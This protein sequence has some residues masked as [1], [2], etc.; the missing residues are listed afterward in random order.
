MIFWSDRCLHFLLK[1]KNRIDQR[2]DAAETHS[3][4]IDIDNNSNENR[5][6]PCRDHDDTM[7]NAMNNKYLLKILIQ[8]DRGDSLPYHINSL[9]WNSHCK[10]NESN[11]S[12]G[13][14]DDDEVNRKKRCDP[15]TTVYDRRWWRDRGAIRRVVSI[16]KSWSQQ[17]RTN[18]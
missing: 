3:R 17:T 11:L 6:K 2:T 12:Y 13:A 18:K 5:N 15:I 9:F 14:Y 4:S 16:E 8:S 1:T 7:A 10:R